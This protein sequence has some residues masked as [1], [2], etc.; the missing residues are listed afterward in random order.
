MRQQRPA[1][2]SDLRHLN[3]PAPKVT[4]AAFVILCA[5]SLTASSCHRQPT[6]STSNQTAKAI[7][8]DSLL[9]TAADVE[10]MSGADNLKA[11][12]RADTHHPRSPHKPPPGACRV[13]DPTVTFGSD[14]TQFRSAVYNRVPPPSAPP[15]P[16]RGPSA[17]APAMPL[18]FA[19]SVAI[20]PDERAARAAF[21][22][23]APALAACSSLH[24]NYYDFTVSQ[25]DNSTVALEYPSGIR[26]IFRVKSSVLIYVDAAGFAHSDQL[27]R[28]V[29]QTISDRI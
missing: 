25:P 7:D 26:N 6:D 19:Q 2:N 8:A 11:N 13:L 10:R 24:A 9:V 29:I 14:W 20:Y 28:A 15:A 12:P 23:L 16:G 27:A 3:Q 1:P 22:R 17:P 18:L 4:V 5:I 21:D